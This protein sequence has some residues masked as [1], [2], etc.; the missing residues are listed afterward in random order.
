MTPSEA[1]SFG[2][3]KTII[4]SLFMLV[5]WLMP[6]M[7]RETKGDFAN[8]ILFFLDKLAHNHIPDAFIFILVLTWF[9]S[10]KASVQIIINKRNWLVVSGQIVILISLIVA[11]Y[12]VLMAWLELKSSSQTGLP[13]LLWD[14]FLGRFLKTA[15][16]LLVAWLW[17]T[18]K[19]NKR[20]AIQQ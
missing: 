8:G 2:R 20:E 1:S 14:Y 5:L 18:W 16:T 13:V 15:I 12:E 6:M 3:R 7:F 10:G 9:F 11:G 19:M 17:A 4:A